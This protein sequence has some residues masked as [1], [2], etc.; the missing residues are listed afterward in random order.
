MILTSFGIYLTGCA[1]KTETVMEFNVLTFEEEQVIQH[2]G[3]EQPYSGEYV[4]SKKDGTYTCK[5][6]DAPLYM[7]ED[8]FDSHCGWPSFDDEI[9]GAVKRV[10]DADGRR[11]EIVCANCGGTQIKIL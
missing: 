10:K 4:K 11:T 8:K 9:K 3:T 2:K 6:C 5:R 1:Q 7:S